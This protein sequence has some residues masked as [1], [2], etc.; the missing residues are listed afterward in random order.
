MHL[1]VFL[2]PVALAKGSTRGVTVGENIARSRTYANKSA[3]Y[4]PIKAW[5]QRPKLV[6]P[7]RYLHKVRCLEV[8][9][10]PKRSQSRNAN[11]SVLRI[12]YTLG[13][14]MIPQI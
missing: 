5:D 11:T 4:R 7:E 12:H 8:T 10:V 3:Q 6:F 14:V 2:R 1:L 9:L 13:M